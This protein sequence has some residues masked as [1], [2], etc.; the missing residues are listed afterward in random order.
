[1]LS[2][3][4]GQS[5]LGSERGALDHF[6]GEAEVEQRAAATVHRQQWRR[7]QPYWQIDVSPLF[8]RENAVPLVIRGAHRDRP[9]GF[10]QAHDP[11]WPFRVSRLE[12]RRR[13]FVR[14]RPAPRRQGR[15]SSPRELT[16]AGAPSLPSL[17]API[18][19]TPV[20]K[21]RSVSQR[22]QRPGARPAASR[23]ASSTLQARR[24]QSSTPQPLAPHPRQSNARCLHASR[25]MQARMHNPAGDGQ[26]GPRQPS[27]G[28]PPSPSFFIA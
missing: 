4:Q 10:G 17:A 23:S 2:E 12:G 1:M 13:F 11:E 24:S 3:P 21:W 26:P 5:Q 14:V 6:T 25:P 8:S 16:R 28:F 9:I 18:D 20:S 27:S 15:S 19:R 7:R 22:R